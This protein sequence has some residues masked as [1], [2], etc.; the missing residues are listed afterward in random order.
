VG[1]FA[2]AWDL[3]EAYIPEGRQEVTNFLGHRF[4]FLFREFNAF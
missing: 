1:A 3:F 2:C 4:A